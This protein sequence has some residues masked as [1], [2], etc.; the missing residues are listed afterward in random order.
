[1]GEERRLPA[2]RRSL[3]AEI[4][5]KFMG[6]A[7]LYQELKPW[8]KIAIDVGPHRLLDSYQADRERDTAL[9]WINRMPSKVKIEEAHSEFERAVS[10]GATKEEITVISATLLDGYPNS[11]QVST[12]GY[13]DLLSLALTS[14]PLDDDDEPFSNKYPISAEVFASSLP[15]IARR[16]NYTPSPAEIYAECRIV[17]GIFKSALAQANHLDRMRES[18]IDVLIALGEYNYDDLGASADGLDDTIP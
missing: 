7:R 14:P 13:I 9:D 18:A 3:L 5:A 12:E 8:L 10:V 6:P 4:E 16:N 2:Q 11:R 15:Q 17:R 1:M